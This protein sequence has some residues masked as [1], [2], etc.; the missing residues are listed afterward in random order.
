[1]KRIV[2]FVIIIII[3]AVAGFRVYQSRHRQKAQSSQE[4]KAQQGIPVETVILKRGSIEARLSIY[5]TLR[6]ENEV[7]IYPKVGGRVERVAVENG[8]RVRAGQLLVQIE[9]KEI[10]DHVRQA[11]AAVNAAREQYTLV[12]KGARPQERSQ[13]EIMVEQARQAYQTAQSTLNRMQGL[14]DAG[15]ISQQQ[16]DEVK[17]QH[18]VA[19]GQYENAR[20]QLSIVQTGARD[21]EKKMAEQGLRQAEAALAFAMEQLKNASITSPVAGVVTSRSIDPGTLTGPGGQQALMTIVDDSSFSMSADISEV[22]LEKVRIG[23][24]VEITIDAIA[25]GRFEGEIAE[26]N[27]A[28][29]EGAR[30]FTLKVKLKEKDSAMKSG[31]FARGSVMIAERADV[32]TVPKDA[33]TSRSGQFGVFVVKNGRAVYRKIQTGIINTLNAEVT[34]GLSEGEEI[35]LAGSAWVKDD[36][37]VNVIKKK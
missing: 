3:I 23:Q 2:Y 27:P 34:K 13:V 17:L 15:V 1:M 30:S 4:I 14:L 8:D 35:I 10:G 20:E 24:G 37:R 36:D 29:S 33:L 26:I 22:D 7:P 25:G 9:T 28:A 21:E 12:Q 16:F 31:M 6:G 18:D 5:G 11:Q 32:L 19:K